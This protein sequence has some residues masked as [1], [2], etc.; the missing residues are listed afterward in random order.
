MIK[1]RAGVATGD[2]EAGRMDERAEFDAE[3]CGRSFKCRFDFGRIE[4]LQ[5]AQRREW[6]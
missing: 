3:F 1:A 4:L 2:G 6:L 5:R